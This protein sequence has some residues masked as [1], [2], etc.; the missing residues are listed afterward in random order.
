RE[1]YHKMRIADVTTEAGVAQGLF[2]HYFKDL[3]S[4]TLE[5]L[6]EFAMAGADSKAIEKN[7]PKGDWFARIYAHNLVVVKSYAK[8]PGIMRCLLQLADEDADFS[9]LLRGNY[10]QQLMWLVEVMP[11]MFPDVSFKPHQ[12]L[13]VVYSLAGIGEGLIRE[14]FINESQALRAAKLSIE[15]FAEL[16]TTMFYRALFLANPEPDQLAYTRNLTAMVKSQ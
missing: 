2:Y 10:R 8:R 13:M 12:A 4:L 14:Y 1:G 16:L 9:A 6:T 3:K 15:E 7:V 11:K 5:V